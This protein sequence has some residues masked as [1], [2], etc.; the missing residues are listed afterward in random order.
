MTLVALTAALI[1]CSSSPEASSTEE[2][3]ARVDP[4]VGTDFGRVT[5]SARAAERIGIETST[6]E[7]VGGEPPRLEIPYAAVLYDST[8]GTYVYT[9]SDPLTFSRHPITVDRIEL[10]QAFLTDGPA[11]GTQIVRVGVMELF[12]VETGFGN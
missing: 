11:P 6:V 1:S 3:P 4:I 12:G 7:S 10:D 5:L 8:G 9:N 2:V